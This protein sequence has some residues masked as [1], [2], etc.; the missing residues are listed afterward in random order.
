TE[1]PSRAVFSLEV[2]T[3]NVSGLHGLAGVSPVGNYIPFV[4]P[5]L[6]AFTDSRSTEHGFA[7]H[8]CA[9]QSIFGFGWMIAAI[10]LVSVISHHINFC[11]AT[12]DRGKY[13]HRVN[14]T[15]APKDHFRLRSDFMHHIGKSAEGF[16]LL[17]SFCHQHLARRC[18]RLPIF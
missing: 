13:K 5:E 15:C 4:V 10:A 3:G 6:D 16:A 9:N 8:S 2:V 14:G 18:M 1:S 12:F 7:K 11:R 17:L